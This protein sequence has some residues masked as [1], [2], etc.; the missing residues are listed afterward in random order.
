MDHAKTKGSAT[1]KPV[2]P[3]AGSASGL[4]NPSLIGAGGKVGSASAGKPAGAKSG[5]G[6]TAAGTAVGGQVGGAVNLALPASSLPDGHRLPP[7]DTVAAALLMDE[8]RVVTGL[9]ERAT[10]TEDERVRAS[11]LARRLI[12]G[13]RANTAKL[14][15]I[16]A[17]LREY[18][19]SSE[20][21]VLLMCLA[22]SLLRI[23]DADTADQLIAEKIADGQWNRHLG[24][25]DSVWVNASTWGLLLTGAVV[26][27][28][29]A[30]GANPVSALKRLVARSGEPV[31]R[32]AVK[33]AV[34]L[35]G[36]QFVLA[37]T[38][39]DALYRARAYEAK[40]Y[41]FSYDMLGEA[42]RAETDAQRYFDLYRDAIEAVG[43]AAKPLT[44]AHP[45]A[46]MARPSVSVKL[47]ALHPRF[48]PAKTSRIT[49]EL[50]PRLAELARLAAARNVP[51][52][53]DAEEQDR[54]HVTLEVFG[55]AYVEAVPQNWAGLGI[56]VQA[57]GRR[58]IPTLRWLRRLSEIH[59]RRIPVRLVK[60]AYW[61]SEIKFAQEAALTDYPVLTRKI[62]ADVSFLAGIRFLL[63]SPEAFYPQF[64][65]HN[66]HAMASAII[67]GGKAPYELQRLHGMGE[68]IYEQVIGAGGEDAGKAGAGSDGGALAAIAISGVTVPCRIYAPVG[69]RSDL[70]AYLVRRL[71][72]N[73]ANSSFLHRLSDNDIP[74]DDLAADPVA[75]VE[76]E[77]QFSETL[78]AP[79][80]SPLAI[81]EPGRQ[82]SPGL[83]LGE[84]GVR[85]ALVG[86]MGEHL[87]T[88][89][90]ASPIIAGQPTRGAGDVQLIRCPHDRRE[91]LGTVA[92]ASAADIETALASA[93]RAAHA[94]DR[95]PVENR[96]RMLELAARLVERDRAKLAAVIIREAGKTLANGVAE[97]QEAADLLRYYA[98]E[99]RRTLGAPLVLPGPTGE[100]NVLEWRAR[101]V[102]L[103]ISPW[104]F[105]LAIFVG[106]IAAALA[107]GNTV[108]AKPAPQT[109]I[110]AF[111]A[112]GLMHE[113]GIPG[114]A[115]HL[116]TGDA[117][118]GAALVRDPRVSGV[119]FTGSTAT[120]SAI[121]RSLAERRGP[122]VPF[123]A[124]TG[125]VNCMIADSSALP[126]QVVRDCVRSSFDSAGQRCSATRVLFV[127]AEIAKRVVPMLSE[128][129]A[130]LDIGDPLDAATDIGPVIDPA[131]QDHLDAQKIRLQRTGSTLIDMAMPE[132]CRAGSYVSPAAYEVAALAPGEH[133]I[134][135]PI[136]QVI[137][138]SRGHLPKVIEAINATGSGLTLGLHSRLQSTADYVAE[139][140]RVGNLYVNRAQIGAR[141]GAQPFGGEGLSGTGPKAGGPHL[142]TRLMTERVRSTDVTATGGNW[143]LLG[144][145]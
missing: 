16:D 129:I 90:A 117:R 9:V 142:L 123:I 27:Y 119:L 85:A 65:T 58:T 106:Q 132:P 120:A 59:G 43:A 93:T 12:L 91:R 74:I 77:L 52:T 114:D 44:S 24:A 131:A 2:A 80:G 133:E 72:E 68:A 38:I 88:A 32:Q 34:K 54:L 56:A 15:G 49:R 22:E 69:P 95:M 141:V 86:E 138:Y 17:F 60:G 101:G 67:A 135:G 71:L 125:G 35:L 105:P 127:H 53:V 82:S 7:L 144:G 121:A 30:K 10:F 61:D 70:V 76:R 28:R 5:A 104:N 26:R 40:G 23:P 108:I 118:V 11:N 14:S 63:A 64:G 19:L 128:A 73:G 115:L 21:G 8:R 39:K 29:D 102:T 143:Q 83:P 51:L 92:G 36:D 116:L 103:A 109:P 84:A 78:P 25:S 94:F 66:A 140:A 107:A 50:Y 46:L 48:E 55:R 79:I 3:R 1:G 4:T 47:S 134:F 137:K 20:E 97:I 75:I 126:E 13:A 110:T 6:T 42:A 98:G 122:M 45:D 33:S 41:R 99:A 100:Y 81:C 113:A 89:F 57:Y 139:H 18:G 31:I 111:L 87:A 112:V 136:L 62:H 145:G 37:P 96:A 130:A 124:E